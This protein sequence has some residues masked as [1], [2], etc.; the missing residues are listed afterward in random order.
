MDL[1]GPTDLSLARTVY[2]NLGLQEFTLEGAQE[3]SAS[4]E[5]GALTTQENSQTRAEIC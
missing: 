1:E 4:G 2:A 5:D 3:L